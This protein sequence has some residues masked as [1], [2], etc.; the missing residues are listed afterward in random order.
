MAA[1]QRSPLSRIRT[2]VMW[3]AAFTLWLV[4]VSVSSDASPYG[5]GQS[6]G[7]F[8]FF[9]LISAVILGWSTKTRQLAPLGALVL[10]SFFLIMG[11][12]ADEHARVVASSDLARAGAKA[13]MAAMTRGDSLPL[14][15][16]AGTSPG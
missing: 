5:L 8:V 11:N 14:K 9:G 16:E 2:V 12:R 13:A 3:L 6:A 15:P 10:G 1:I 4:I 7:K